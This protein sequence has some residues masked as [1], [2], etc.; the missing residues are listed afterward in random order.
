MLPVELLLML[1]VSNAKV[2]FL[3]SSQD[4]SVRADSFGD[5]YTFGIAGTGG[6]S[7]S[8]STLL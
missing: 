7:E 2:D 8:S 4:I 5:S 6:T 1:L 3:L